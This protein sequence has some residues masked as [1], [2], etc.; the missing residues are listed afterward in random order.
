MQASRIKFVRFFE[1]NPRYRPSKQQQPEV[2]V[3]VG[4]SYAVFVGWG[5]VTLSVPFSN[6]PTHRSDVIAVVV[7]GSYANVVPAHASVRGHLNGVSAVLRS[8]VKNCYSCKTA[9]Q[10]ALGSISLPPNRRLSIPIV[11]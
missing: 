9:P 5:R 6:R 4:F 3:V 2:V 10:F 8:S 7:R 11:R 1:G